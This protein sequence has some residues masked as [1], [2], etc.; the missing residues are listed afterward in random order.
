M[1]GD[2]EIFGSRCHVG[3][4]S[5]DRSGVVAAR[6]GA[7]HLRGLLDRNAERSAAD[8]TGTERA[9]TKRAS[10]VAVKTGPINAPP[11]PRFRMRKAREQDLSPP[12]AGGLRVA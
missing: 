5:D 1:R 4:H 2:C 6:S 3:A 8:S 11:Q 10:T 12:G 7:H 9:S